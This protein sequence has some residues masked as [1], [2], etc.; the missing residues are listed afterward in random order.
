MGFKIKGITLKA[1]FF[2][3]QLIFVFVGSSIAIG[4]DFD[5]KKIYTETSKAVVVIAGFEKGQQVMSKGTGSIISGDGLVLTNAHVVINK[6]ESRPFNNL[7]VF[8]KPDKITG[9]LKQD[10]SRKY[11]AKIIRYS[12]ELDLA[13]IKIRS[14]PSKQMPPILK[15]SDSDLVSIGDPVVAIGHPEQGGLWTLTTGTIS[16]HRMDYGNITGKNVFQTEASLNRGNSGGPLIDGFGRIIGINSMISRRAEDGL[17]ITGINFSIK[18]R[19]ALKWLDSVGVYIKPTSTPIPPPSLVKQLPP[20]LVQKLPT[21]Q[22]SDAGIVSIPK[23]TEDNLK[24]TNIT[25]IDKKDILKPISPK[26]TVPQS[27]KILTVLRPFKDKD[28][29]RQV[30][31]E[32]EDMINEMKGKENLIDFLK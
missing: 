15:F 25:P 5:P 16:S 17:A 24:E 23:V 27:S 21:P 20:P 2:L 6:K 4:K 22:A 11:K 26:K 30:E 12:E 28:L 13:L 29:M 7:R 8:L 9:S 14:A 18:S 1:T 3:L 10:T 31:D 32:M 19:V